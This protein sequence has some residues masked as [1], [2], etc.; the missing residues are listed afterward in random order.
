MAAVWGWVITSCFTMCVGMAM[1]EIVS[2]VPSA[3]GVFLLL[4]QGVVML[5]MLCTSCSC[6]CIIYFA[7]NDMLHSIPAVHNL[8]KAIKQVGTS[9]V[10][11]AVQQ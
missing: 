6:A 5:L 11:P 4:H 1:A 3:G 2:S 10:W 9:Q 7:D 8:T